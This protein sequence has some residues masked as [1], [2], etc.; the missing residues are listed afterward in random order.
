MYKNRIRNIVVHEPDGRDIHALA[1]KVS[2]FHADVI[3]RKL[4]QSNLTTK[5][6]IA[7]INK[8]IDVLKSREVN[9]FIK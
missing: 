3:E 1:D 7:V 9:G 8:I 6:K 4:N 5:Q 2:E